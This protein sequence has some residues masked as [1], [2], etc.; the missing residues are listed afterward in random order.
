MRH[1]GAVDDDLPAGPRAA[2]WKRVQ[3]A[4]D[5]GKPKTA[6]EALAGVEEAAVKEKAW[7]EAARAIA[8]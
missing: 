1:A 6:A 5:E 4:L 8:T 7:A 2:A 3:Q